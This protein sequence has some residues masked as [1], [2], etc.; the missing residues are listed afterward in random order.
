MADKDYK[1]VAGFI[2]F[3]P[4]EREVNGQTIR[5]VTIRALGSECPY[6]KVTVWEEFADIEL[7]RGQFLAVDGAFEARVAPNK[8]GVQTTY[9][10]IS[11]KSIVVLEPV[12]RGEASVVTK[13]KATKERAF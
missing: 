4:E 1:S 12:A 2:Q 9:L 13:K 5:D 7:E 10:N 3:D 11:A 6:I 8:A